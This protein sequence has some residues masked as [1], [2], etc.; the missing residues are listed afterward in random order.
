MEEII[1]FSS[2]GKSLDEFI[3]KGPNIKSN[4]ENSLNEPLAGSLLAWTMILFKLSHTAIKDLI[5][6][7][8]N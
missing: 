4:L 5:K 2:R 7:S 3:I 1:A 8:K 6:Q